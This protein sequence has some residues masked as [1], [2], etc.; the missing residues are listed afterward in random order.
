[1]YGIFLLLHMIGTAALGFYLILPFIVGGI[2]KLSLGAQEGGINAIR[3]ANRFAQY[4]L[5]VQ[6]IT[7]GYMMS[8]GEYSV[9]WM[10]IITVLLLA[11]FAIGGIMGKPLKGALAGIR[12]KREVAAETAKLRTFSIILAIL[13]LVMIYLMVYAF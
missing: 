13:L 5:V 2:Q 8:K 4:G 9:A 3:V 1:M 12:E 7:G 6:L 10:I 11:M